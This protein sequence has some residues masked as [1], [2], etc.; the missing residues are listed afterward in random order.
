MDKPRR[1]F[2]I[3]NGFGYALFAVVLL[4][5]SIAPFDGAFWGLFPQTLFAVTFA[6]IIRHPQS[7]PLLLVGL[8]FL[9]RDFLYFQP[10]GLETFLVV[11]L[12]LAA[13]NARRGLSE[14][15]LREWATLA[16]GL[17][18]LAVLEMITLTL[19]FS[20]R[21]DLSQEVISIMTT[22]MIYPLITGIVAGVFN[23][24]RLAQVEAKG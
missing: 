8:V 12:C 24:P 18:L 20:A 21:N 4:I 3:P 22:V 15:Y 11:F 7:V 5:V 6:L 9:L 23:M 13:R 10:L 17:I 14:T 2:E 19:L 1:I 16:L